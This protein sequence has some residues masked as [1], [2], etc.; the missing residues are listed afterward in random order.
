MLKQKS[1]GA[2]QQR[3]LQAL[4]LHRS[5][6]LPAAK[7]LYKD[8]LKQNPN[9][10]DA[11]HMLGAL[12]IQTDN[13]QRAAVL[14]G[15][16]VRIN[17]NDAT[18]HSNRGAALLGLQRPGEALDSHDR[19]IALDP[20][21]ADAHYNRGN[22]LIALDRVDEG[23]ASYDRAIALKPDY[24]SAHY[25][26]SL[27]LL[28]RGDFG[29]AWPLFEWRKG[30]GRPV[31]VRSFPQPQWSGR[32]SL[33]AKS[34]FIH[35]EQGFGDT[36]QFVRYARLARARGA[37][38]ILSA[39]D[40][41]VW[42]LKQLEPEIEVIG[43]AE[44]P[45]VFNYHCPLMSL[46]LAFGTTLETVPD[47]SPPLRADATAVAAWSTRLSGLAGPKVGLAWAG[48]PGA[49]ANEANAVDRRRSIELARLAPLLA[50]PGVSFVSLQKGGPAGQLHDLAPRLRPLDLMDEAHD[51][52]DTAALI[53]N[54]DLVVT[55]DTSVAHL[56]GAMGKP[57]W[58]LSRFDGCW[59]WLTGREDSPWYPT[60]RLFRQ[61]A[62]GDWETVI[63]RV[64]ARLAEVA[65]GRLDPV[66]PLDSVR[67]R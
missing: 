34:L 18:A 35:W 24:A 43:G 22:V 13:L 30:E 6:D 42:L 64:A 4:D 33:A 48:G 52:A 50:T 62:P 63:A 20:N 36:L 59:R 25:N 41:L 2:L 51:F 19:A 66:W 26:K 28:R 17:P 8:I 38:V 39:Q 44:Q 21:H 31:A 27:P 29:E 55:V 40:P 23:L 46:P 57:V 9:H 7:K 32:E 1:A 14:L 15:K 61:A 47:Q 12:E 54:L 3:F 10:F 58:I 45:A 67:P 53:A 5:G 11:L 65:A 56:A 60:A 37:R 16:A 49:R